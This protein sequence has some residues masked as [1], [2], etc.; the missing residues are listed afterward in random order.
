M[1]KKF[2]DISSSIDQ[3]RTDLL[4]AQEEL[5]IDRMNSGKIERV[6]KCTEALIHWQDI[7]I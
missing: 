7:H 3:A 1:S 4:Q 2:S 5:V 6:K